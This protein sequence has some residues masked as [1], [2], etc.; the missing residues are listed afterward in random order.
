MSQET[1]VSSKQWSKN[2]YRTV[3]LTSDNCFTRT[4]HDDWEL[5]LVLT[6]IMRC[7]F[8]RMH[9]ASKIIPEINAEGEED[10]KKEEN[11]DKEKNVDRKTLRKIIWNKIIESLGLNIVSND[12]LIVLS[13]FERWW[14]M[15]VFTPWNDLTHA[16]VAVV[17]LR[18]MIFF[19][20][21]YLCQELSNTNSCEKIFNTMMKSFSCFFTRILRALFWSLRYVLYFCGLQ[22]YYIFKIFLHWFFVFH[23][24]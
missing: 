12:H 19:L 22:L 11:V 14:R 4:L 13:G 16:T 15:I 18:S 24:S 23:F 8:Y 9:C 21:E 2:A 20:F 3:C 7:E 6:F 17:K 1:N 5:I 10:S